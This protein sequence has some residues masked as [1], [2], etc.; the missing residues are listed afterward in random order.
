MSGIIVDIG[1][2]DGVFVSELAKRYPDRLIIGIDPHQKSLEKVS[3]KTEKKEQRGGLKNAVFVLS[4]I[5]HLP[6]ELDGKANQI[7]IN[8]PW[9]SL[10]R[11]IVLGEASTFQ[12][13]ARISRPGTL[14]DIVLGYAEEIER[15]EMERM[16]LPS[17][18]DCAYIDHILSPKIQAFGFGLEEVRPVIRA[19]IE[20][21]PSSW[22]KRL[23]FSPQRTFFFLRLKRGA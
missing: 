9:G 19:E 5:E 1:T 22:A 4:D 23:R 6:S 11:G 10:L 17:R 16:K 18:F 7:F 13:L 15:K 14:I 20:N 3:R 2:G 8:F 21:F 12:A